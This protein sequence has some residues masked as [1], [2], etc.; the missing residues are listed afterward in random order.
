MSFRVRL[1]GDFL[2]TDGTPRYPDIGTDVLDDAGLAWS[3]MDEHRSEL[4]PEQIGDAAGVV[5]L[6][7]A[8]TAASLAQAHDLLAIGR[9]G[10]GYD[11][12]D[13]AAC[14]DRD[15]A[16]F[17]TPGAVDRPVAEATV[18]WI[19]A[20]GHKVIQK[21][22]LVREGRWDDR[23][24]FMGQEVRDRTVGLVGCGR[25]GRAVI[26]LLAGFG[27][28]PPLVFDPYLSESDAKAIGVR[29]VDLPELLG[30]S[31]YVSV[32]CPLTDETR[33]L[34]G[35][36][37]LAAMKPGAYLIN[38]ARGGIVD[39]DALEAALKNGPIA[40]AALDCFAEEPVTSPSRF[41]GCENVVLAPT[42]SRGRASSSA[43]SGGWRAAAW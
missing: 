6:T 8:I 16:L 12:V 35:A 3:I 37:E 7:P 20:L 42:R 43:T 18:T 34:I 28:K 36:D 15:V 13:V 41:T 21:D 40:G 25:I 27:M 24:G 22:R 39:E 31:D 17:I 32:H 5:V 2:D 10:V 1:T 29:K 19:L 26:G 14:T 33:G 23:S 4:A 11:T 9:F 38:T 30:E